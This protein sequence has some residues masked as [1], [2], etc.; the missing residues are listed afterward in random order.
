MAYKPD[1]VAPW[2][3]ELTELRTRILKRDPSRPG[4]TAELMEAAL[5]HCDSLLR[6][7]AGAYLERDGLQHALKTERASWQR[8]VDVC[9]TACLI[10]DAA[11]LIRSANRPAALLLSVSAQRLEGRQ[12]LLFTRDRAAFGILLNRLH[13]GSDH[14]RGKM[15]I[16]PRERRS[17]E[18]E[19]LVVPRLR[20]DTANW[21]WFVWQEPLGSPVHQ[22]DTHALQGDT[23]YPDQG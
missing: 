21:V 13:R 22:Q 5:D 16:R 2:S 7:L 1:P 6:A 19:F 11:G 12:L 15:V 18:V 9:P 17:T 8:F 3:S 10:T 20:D 4:A 23:S 14:V